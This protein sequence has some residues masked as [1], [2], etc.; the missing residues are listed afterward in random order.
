M[1]CSQHFDASS[2]VQSPKE[3]SLFY[4]Q[5][6]LLKLKADT[7]PTLRIMFDAPQVEA[8]HCVKRSLPLIDTSNMLESTCN[9]TST[10]ESQCND[11]MPSATFDDDTPTSQRIQSI[12]NTTALPSTSKDV[13]A[14][15]KKLSYKVMFRNFSGYYTKE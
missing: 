5:K 2:F 14:L 7:I 11:T 12:D 1:I 13:S 3:K 15:L 6:R 8:V 4:S 10:S 9:D